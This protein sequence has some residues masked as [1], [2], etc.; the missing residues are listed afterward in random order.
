MSEKIT[1]V[2][3]IENINKNFFFS[4]PGGWDILTQI[5]RHGKGFQKFKCPGVARG[6]GRGEC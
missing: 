4:C 3:L 6:R 5:C 2:K 1:A